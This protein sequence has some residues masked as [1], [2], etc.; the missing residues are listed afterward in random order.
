MRK[1]TYWI[2]LLTP[3]FILFTS[4]MFSQEK[5]KDKNKELIQFSGVVVEGDSLR[6][7]PFTSIMIKNTNRGTI[8]DY[9]GYFS[10]VAQKT[11][12]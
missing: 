2:L 10:F 4:S 1:N 3:L 11:I 7:V 12:P 8:C 9:Y 5:A 6:P